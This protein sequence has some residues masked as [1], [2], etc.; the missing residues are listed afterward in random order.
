MY[1]F[2][3]DFSGKTGIRIDFQSAGMDTLNLDYNTKINLYRL[4][5]EGLNNVKKHADAK[6]VNIRLISSFPNVIFRINDDG[7]G[8]DLKERLAKASSEKR[9]GLRSMHERVGL[10]Q[11]RINIDSSPGKGTNV[12]IEV[13]YGDESIGAGKNKIDQ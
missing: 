9:M 4:L 12:F 10:L 2:C 5:Q 13:P 6:M 11:G 7:K 1:Q 3:K 8:F